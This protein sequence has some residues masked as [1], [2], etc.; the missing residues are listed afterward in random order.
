MKGRV[1]QQRLGERLTHGHAR[2]EGAVGVLE[3][4]LSAG[5][6]AAQLDSPTAAR[7][8]APRNAR[9]PMSAPSRRNARRPTVDLPQP[10]SPTRASVSP[11]ATESETPST[12]RTTAVG[13]A[14]QRA[15][16]HEVL[17][18]IF[19]RQEAF[20]HTNASSGAFQQRE[21]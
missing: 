17:G 19:Q 7:G 4:E 12:A 20:A 9:C 13:R 15:P 14:N 16:D 11:A 3:D 18:C 8:R 5:A 21:R 1:Q 2:V 10:D 6:G